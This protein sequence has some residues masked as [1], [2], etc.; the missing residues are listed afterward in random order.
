MTKPTHRTRSKETPIRVP[1][2]WPRLRGRAAALVIVFVALACRLVALAQ[3]GGHPMLRP[4]GVLDDAVY[5]QLAQRVA[6][7]D[8]L[9]GPEAYALAPFYTYFLGVIFALTGG[10]IVAGRVVQVLLG[11][12]AVAL[13]M[14]TAS[15]WFGKRA[16]LAAGAL[17][18]LTGVFVFN[19]M[20][21]LQSAIDPFLTSLALF[22]VARAAR[23]QSIPLFAAAGVS[24]GAL[25]LNRPN[26][27]VCV[28]ATAAIWLLVRRSRAAVG[29]SVALVLGAALLIAP[30]AIRNRIVSGEWV[31]ITSHGG[32]NFYIGNGEG[33][34]GTWRQVDGV[35]PSIE[36]QTRDVRLVAGK[37]LQH[38]VSSGE[39]SDYFYTLAWRWIGAHPAAWLRLMAWKAAL[40]C[41][42]T[43]VA[44]N[45]SYAYFS[46]DESSLLSVLIV[47]PWLII[48]L[49]I[50]GL[51][52]G[53]GRHPRD[54]YLTWAAFAPIYALSVIAF[55]V[56][57][58]YRLPLLVPLLIGGGAAVDR[59]FQW[60]AERANR[61]LFLAAAGLLA[62]FVF[63][64]WPMRIDDGRL[65][66]REEVI[67]RLITDGRLPE[68][69]TRIAEAESMH[70]RRDILL[71]RV[72][73]A[74]R[75]GNELQRALKYLQRALD[76]T[77]ANE[78]AQVG[79][80]EFDLGETLLQAGQPAEAIRHLEAARRR[81]VRPTTS[82]YDL[83]EAYRLSG[84]PEQARATLSSM[85]GAADASGE[86]LLQLAETAL[87]LEAPQLA[88][89]FA[90]LALRQIPAAAR[91]HELLG[92]ALVLQGKR[93]EGI[94]ELEKAVQLD[95]NSPGA[96][97][98]LGLSYAGA[99]NIVAARRALERALAL[100]PA[101]E[102]ARM[103]LERLK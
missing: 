42:A 7:G 50:F 49:G 73:L 34:D 38:P 57:S 91:A 97:F 3:L 68:A 52:V 54:A 83:T 47:G 10:S 19:E 61:R 11:T 94:V 46:R 81:G 32:L 2:R 20:L 102:D 13:V 58:R 89:A 25:A 78:G 55:F 65:R 24:L 39:A 76:A 99:Q 100:D 23:R 85:L 16:G 43:E 88:D 90:R 29:Q 4:E 79:S 84:Q 86:G 56:S 72:G 26:A 41:N 28:I 9:L 98:H 33:A 64:N 53:A 82:A 35:T 95:P 22:A 51:A 14:Q 48:P 27:V 21:I 59:L 6:S 12:A 8:L 69:E 67:V 74:F 71:Y 17:A 92:S 36:G 60:A 37:A 30:F 63:V 93:D 70:P 75:E 15:D 80:I 77:P 31:L 66:Q 101:Y 1:S 40:I 5:V 103:L 96:Y 44:L 62:L 87:V 18:A 45:Y